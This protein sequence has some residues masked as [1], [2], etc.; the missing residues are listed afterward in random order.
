[1]PNLF[2]VDL[3]FVPIDLAISSLERKDSFPDKDRHSY[4]LVTFQILE[5]K[6][7][8]HTFVN[9]IFYSVSL[10]LVLETF[11]NVVPDTVFE[12]FKRLLVLILVD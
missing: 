10:H 8:D 11:S 3:I 5:A 6:M 9:V 7:V 2:A 1:M 12:R 4:H